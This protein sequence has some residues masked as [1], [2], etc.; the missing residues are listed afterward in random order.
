MSESFAMNF[1]KD[2]QNAVRKSKD[3]FTQEQNEK[4]SLILEQMTK[5]NTYEIM[6]L[7]KN[8][9]K[10][11][12][13]EYNWPIFSRPNSDPYRIKPNIEIPFLG[14]VSN[15]SDLINKITLGSADKGEVEEEVKEVVKEKP[16]EKTTFN[17]ILTG[18]DPASKVKFIKCVKDVLGLGLKESKDKVEE[19]IKGP[20]TLFK[21]VSKESHG[22]VLEQLLAAGGQ[23]EFQ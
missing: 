15:V 16:V 2:H 23:V 13:S 10:A 9:Q 17:I 1:N 19:T 12:E 20:V 11:Q 5:L 7:R 8:V 22:K 6:A 14:P 4:L 18:Y 21:S 3:S